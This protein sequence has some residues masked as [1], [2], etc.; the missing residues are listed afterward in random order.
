MLRARTAVA[1]GV[2]TCLAFAQQACGTAGSTD[3]GTPATPPSAAPASSASPEPDP[4]LTGKNQVVIAPVGSFE[5]VLA[6]DDKGRLNTTDGDSEFSLFVLVPA[7]SGT[8]QIQTAKPST[9]GQP[10]CMGIKENGTQPLTVVAAPCDAERDG[11][12]FTIGVADEAYTINSAG[13]YLRVSPE[14]GLIA[15]EIGDGPAAT[16]FT[17]VDNGPAPGE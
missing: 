9:D 13:A 15:E 11:Q 2:V 8:H 6:V 3:A 5:S 10:A 4:L 16:T 17:L 1:L 12:L 7:T 14:L